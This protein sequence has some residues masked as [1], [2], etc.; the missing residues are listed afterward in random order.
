MATKKKAAKPKASAAAKKKAVKKAGGLSMAGKLGRKAEPKAPA[1]KKSSKPEVQ[2]DETLPG[3]A[4]AVEKLEARKAELER[5]LGV[6]EKIAASDSEFAGEAQRLIDEAD[7]EMKVVDEALG[8]SGLLTAD[9][10][11]GL[12]MVADG[13]KKME[14]AFSIL[15]PILALLHIE[16]CRK[17][18]EYLSSLR[19]N[20]EVTYEAPARIKDLKPENEDALREIFG[21]S[22]DDFFAIVKKMELNMTALEADEEFGSG[23]FDAIIAYCQ[24]HDKDPM[25]FVIESDVMTAKGD[26]L[27][28][29]ATKPEVQEQFEQAEDEGLLAPFKAKLKEK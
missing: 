28:Q 17:K 24:E 12:K 14:V 4:A 3:H 18:G 8:C 19:V 13:K 22:Y 10:L 6:Y 23:L 7:A 5:R 11:K 21:D 20:G 25:D 15:D 9:Y 2:V 16:T 26:L 29:R 27:K 1:A